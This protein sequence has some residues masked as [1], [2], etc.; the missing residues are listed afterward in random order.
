MQKFLI[1]IGG[2]VVSILLVAPLAL[3]R[4]FVLKILWA[5]FV[6]PLG[7][8]PLGLAHAIGFSVIVGLLTSACHKE[9]E[10]DPWATFAGAMGGPLGAL[11]FGAI[12]HLFM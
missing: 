6:I 3:L 11:A 2:V 1:A 10:K 9:D 8:M 5:W 4:G 12:V 7:V